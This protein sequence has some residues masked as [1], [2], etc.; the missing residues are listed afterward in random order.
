MIHTA[1]SLQELLKS[2]GNFFL[3]TIRYEETTTD[4]ERAKKIVDMPINQLLRA[5]LFLRMVETSAEDYKTVL[6]SVIIKHP[7][8]DILLKR[9]D[10]SLGD[11]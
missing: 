10:N 5:Y 2:F 8:G 6:R 1:E 3:R 9:M 11:S 4:E 7:L